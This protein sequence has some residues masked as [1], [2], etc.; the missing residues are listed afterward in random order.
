M[1]DAIEAEAQ[2][3]ANWAAVRRTCNRIRDWRRRG[4]CEELI[5]VEYRLMGRFLR[6]WQAAV[7]WQ[8]EHAK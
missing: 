2:R 7:Q 1:R 8:R 4:V 3:Q 5:E 6:D